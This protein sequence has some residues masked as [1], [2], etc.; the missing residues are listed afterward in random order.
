MARG[1]TLGQLLTDL[2]A[3]CGLSLNS[4]HNNQVRD[5]H[6]YHLNR[7]QNWLW[8]D[9]SWPHL[10][11]ERFLHT[12]AGQR[13][14]DPSG[15]KKRLNDGTLEAAGDIK[16]DRIT[17]VWVRDG[18]LWR[19]LDPGISQEHYNEWDSESD[20]RAWPPQR[21]AIT[22]DEQIE[23]WPRPDTNGNT[24]TLENMLKIVGT[25]NLAP[26]VAESHRADLDDTV[27]VLFAAAEILKGED[28]QKKLN[29]TNRRLIKICG[30]QSPQ[31]RTKLFS[32]SG[33]RKVLRG[34]PTVYYRP[35][36]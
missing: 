8:E 31:R 16:I 17:E 28:A 11:V 2:R 19:K 4:A 36:S 25:R 23:I 32:K 30:N 3:E 24:T 9:Y 21:W 1:K 10:K 18:D 27:T 6:V 13:Y 14:Y 12:Q 5:T 34:P 26:L 33:D 20:E 22:E 15:C 35:P 7:V 29:L